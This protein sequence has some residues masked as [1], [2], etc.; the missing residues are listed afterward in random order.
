MLRSLFEG[1][2]WATGALVVA[3]LAYQLMTTKFV[4]I[5]WPF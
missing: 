5:N 3:Y 4:F 1:M 2:A